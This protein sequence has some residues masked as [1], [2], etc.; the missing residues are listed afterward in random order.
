[1]AIITKAELIKIA[2]EM[3][4]LSDADFTFWS[5]LADHQINAAFFGGKAKLAYGY[6]LAHII[7]VSKPS[8]IESSSNG[9]API[10]SQTVGGTSVTYGA[11]LAQ[12]PPNGGSD[13]QYESTAYGRAFLSFCKIAGAGGLA[14]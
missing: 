14:I 6:L 8:S 9:G 7:S 12:S 13:G 4:G 2:P 3:S 11:Y 10:V 5:T 1:M